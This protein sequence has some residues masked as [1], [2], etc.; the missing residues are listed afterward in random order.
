MREL[1]RT[2]EHIICKFSEIFTGG[3]QAH[4]EILVKSVDFLFGRKKIILENF[5]VRTLAY[6][7]FYVYRVLLGKNLLR[8]H[9]TNR[10][11]LPV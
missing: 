6:S 8:F 2:F 5:T 1:K 11:I 3:K 4:I 10:L 9:E 7:L